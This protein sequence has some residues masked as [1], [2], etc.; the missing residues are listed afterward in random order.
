MHQMRQIAIETQH[1][2]LGCFHAVME[3]VFTKHGH[4]R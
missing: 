4:V 1:V 3:N 2:I